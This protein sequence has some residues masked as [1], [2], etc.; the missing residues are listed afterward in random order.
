MNRTTRNH[1]QE[2][3]Q[4][5]NFLPL[6]GETGVVSGVV[7]TLAEAGTVVKPLK[8]RVGE[9]AEWSNARVC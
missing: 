3:S 8:N 1:G 5:E 6:P 2:F 7:T 9:V 4:C